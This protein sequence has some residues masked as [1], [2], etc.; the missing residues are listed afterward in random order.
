MNK[1]KLKQIEKAF[2]LHSLN[3]KSVAD[4]VPNEWFTAK[5]YQERNKVGHST[6]NRQLNG[7]VKLGYSEIKKFKVHSQAGNLRPTVHYRLLA[8]K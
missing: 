8:K 3:G 7:L 6:A 5:E 1:I 4:V 2:R